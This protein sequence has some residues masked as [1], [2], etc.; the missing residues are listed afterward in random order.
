MEPDMANVED[1]RGGV[2]QVYAEAILA[3]AEEQGVADEILDELGG[4][5]DLAAKDRAF[6][7]FLASPLVEPQARARTFEKILR[8]RASDLL[9]DALQVINRKGR[10]GL[11][12]AIAAAY[13]AAHRRLRGRIQVFVASAVPLTEAL[14]AR[15]GEAAAR[16]SGRTPELVESVD[17]KLL[18]GMVVRV[19]DERID[20]SVKTR[21]RGLSEAL[22]RRASQEVQSGSRYVAY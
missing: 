8:G 1:Q 21:L 3:L 10:L 9:V 15:L 13:R 2:A 17:V 19:R 14:R 12:P 6:E 16:Y 18:G 20:S 11:L 4:L 7:S 5:A 22:L